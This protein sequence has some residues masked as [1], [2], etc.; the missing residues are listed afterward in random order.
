M[1][2]VSEEI[3]MH[4]GVGAMDGAPG[5]GSG[6]YPLGSGADPN[7]HS[8]NFASRVRELRKQGLSDKE[9]VVA[10]DLKSTS[11]LRTQYSISVNTERAA[12]VSRARAML[13]EGKTQAEVARELGV[14]ESTLRSLLNEKSEARTNSA[15]ATAD[16]L[17]KQI[18]E[19][20]MI[21][22]GTGVE[23]ELNISKE[24]L[25][26]ALA[27]LEEE[28]YV[29]HGGGVPQVTNPGK[30][31]NIRVICPPGTEHREIYNFENVHTV[32]DYKCRL[33][34]NG[35][36]VFEKGFE[37]PASLDSSRLQI[38]TKDY[39]CPDG[40]A[41]IEKDGLIEIRPG[42]A[43]LD[44][45]ESQYA[46]V[47]ILVDGTHYIKGMAVYSDNLPDGVDVAFNTNKATEAAA[48]K[49]IKTTDPNNPFNSLLREEGGQYHYIDE[50]GEKQLGL[51]NKTRHEGD[52]E[53]WSD[54]LPSQ[55]L[56]KQSQQLI[57]RQLG[58]ALS[59]K[60]AEYEEIC[61]LT[62]PA[63]KRALLQDFAEGCDADAV[64]LQAAALPRQ[65]YQVIL[66]VSSL[67]E[68]E[69]YAPNYQDGE[70]VALIRYPH[71]GTFEIP[72]L[73]V[74]NKNPEGRE[75][76]GD[77]PSD[78]VG[79]N[80]EVAARLSG[81]DF[82]GDTVMVIPCNS[83]KSSVKINSTPALK[84][85][86]GFEPT[87]EYAYTDKYT[88]AKGKDHYIRNG[89]EFKAM[90]KNQT[91][92]EMGKVS[93]LITDMTLKGA[94]EDEL[95]RAVRHSMVVIDA[96]KHHLDWK[97]SEVDN[98]IASLKKKY[99]YRVDE[100]GNPHEGASTLISQAKSPV[101]VLKRKGT[102]R[103]DPDTGELIYK[104]VEE[105][106]VD[107][108]GKTRV[109]TQESTKM[110]ETKDART[111]I[112]DADTPQERA[113]A[114]YANSLKAMANNARK[115]I[116]STGRLK[117]NASAKETYR[118]EVDSLMAQ[119]NVAWKNAPRERQ[120][121]LAANS[122]IEAMKKANPDMTKKEIQ[123]QGQMALSRARSRYGAQ[124]TKINITP[125]GWEA[126]QAGAISDSILTE[127][128]RFADGE[129]VRAYA[130]PRTTTTISTGKQARIKAM[131]NSGYTTS[132]IASALGVSN[133]TVRKYMK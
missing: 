40:H 93:N 22:V 50:N 82:D 64:S 110:A 52:W 86:E 34:E 2:R 71:G 122:E 17:R 21:D 111:L 84:D 10:L 78:G 116:L 109:R 121:Q 27:I 76:L 118:E 29:V 100:D 98:D 87:T 43:D 14:N 102:P 132:E 92:M 5:R 56:S 38:R 31:T 45:G 62:N 130:T 101:N 69:I 55:F 15:Q 32:T 13:E 65:K 85:L 66:P 127:I 95:A 63:V 44:L 112:S 103:I 39:I 115:E 35:N 114:E 19:K 8:G 91:Q 79:I 123:K 54:S 49:P 60:R 107:K 126:I 11:E 106:Y 33:D 41:A 97:Q 129:Q 59:D 120:A 7:Q 57:D 1:N 124:R 77:T 125:R 70:T 6:R 25:N 47:R 28:G 73:K 72:I 104:E 3:L 108:K 83:A 113:Y 58:L 74:N 75:M 12:K 94:T 16:F 119:L 36:E 37:Y 53:D 80:H 42:C 24:K 20:G 30:Q 9:I 18:D 4:Y 81:A 23:R 90:T 51:I 26:Q 88:D 128:L 46:Q 61:S 131:A 133:S 105:T 68:N 48:L 96:E 117:Y 99:Q 89:R 67:S